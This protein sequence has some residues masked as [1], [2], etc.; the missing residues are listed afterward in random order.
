MIVICR[1]ISAQASAQTA[2][3]DFTVAIL[4]EKVGLTTVLVSTTL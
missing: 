2:A 1:L 4:P 3:G